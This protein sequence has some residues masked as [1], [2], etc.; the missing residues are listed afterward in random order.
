MSTQN[1]QFVKY[2]ADGGTIYECRRPEAD[3]KWTVFRVAVPNP[4]PGEIKT[5]HTQTLHLD[6]VESSE[7]EW[8][9]EYMKV[10]HSAMEGE[11]IDD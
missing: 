6:T 4:G 5:L 8:E 2:P 10:L 3:G 11:F 7:D 9:L 1:D